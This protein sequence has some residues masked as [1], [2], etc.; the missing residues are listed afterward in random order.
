MIE[1]TKVTNAQYVTKNIEQI[2]LRTNKIN[3]N[4]DYDND[5][6]NSRKIFKKLKKSTNNLLAE[7]HILNSQI[8]H[9]NDISVSPIKNA[10]YEI[11][12]PSPILSPNKPKNNTPVDT[13]ADNSVSFYPKTLALTCLNAFNSPDLPVVKNKNTN[14]PIFL[15]KEIESRYV[16]KKRLNLYNE[17]ITNNFSYGILQIPLTIISYMYLKPIENNDFDVNIVNIN[18]FYNIKFFSS[19]YG[20]CKLSL[21]I[22]KKCF[23]ADNYYLYNV[24]RTTNCLEKSICN[25]NYQRWFENI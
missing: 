6:E 5:D 23:I 19:E 10:L 20:L 3:E 25:N 24:N 1:Q 12:L 9:K 14:F 13:P 17:S 4:F 21:G 8:T 11:T 15:D 18:E 22:W 16:E 7:L 2:L